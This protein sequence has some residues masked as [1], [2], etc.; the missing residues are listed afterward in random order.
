MT[1]FWI[2]RIV[3]P[4]SRWSDPWPIG[5]FPRK[6]YYKRDAVALKK[7]IVKRGG[8]ATVEREKN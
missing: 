7:E 1:N 6:F 8:E 4:I 5:Y 3:K 2:D